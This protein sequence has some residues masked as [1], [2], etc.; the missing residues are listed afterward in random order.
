MRPVTTTLPRAWC[1]VHGTCRSRLDGGHLH[2]TRICPR[3]QP[4]PVLGCRCQTRLRWLQEQTCMRPWPLHCTETG[5]TPNRATIPA[6]QRPHD[7]CKSPPRAFIEAMHRTEL[8]SL[9]PARGL[10]SAAYQA[11]TNS[12]VLYY[13]LCLRILSTNVRTWTL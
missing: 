1:S 9:F 13:S 7:D 10:Q 11:C 4:Q 8:Q 3:R 12:T 5:T 2:A 6:L